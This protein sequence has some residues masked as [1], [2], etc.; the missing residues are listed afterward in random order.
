MARETRKTPGEKSPSESNTPGDDSPGD[1]ETALIAAELINMTEE[2]L[3][4]LAGR[5][6]DTSFDSE[7]ST[8][9]LDTRSEKSLGV[10]R[11]SISDDEEEK[12]IALP[13][14]VT[15]KVAE[16]K[17][18]ATQAVAT[19]KAKQPHRSG[20]AAGSGSE[21]GPD[22]DEI[23]P[24]M[25]SQKNLRRLYG[26]AIPAGEI[27]IYDSA[28]CRDDEELIALRLSENDRK[29][30]Y[31]DLFSQN[32]MFG[33]KAKTKHRPLTQEE[34]IKSLTAIGPIKYSAG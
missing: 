13:L 5:A 16:K 14:A 3:H 8:F 21:W 33:T 10:D 11:L 17:N 25:P 27:G 7:H 24:W 4:Q 20:A 2:E 31:I 18:P 6:I 28:M 19:S 1:Q 15:S 34:E 9:A 26:K 30:Y 22:P 12:P 29:M 23:W 32:K